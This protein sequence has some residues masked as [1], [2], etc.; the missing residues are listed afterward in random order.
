MKKMLYIMGVEWNW[1]FQRPQILAIKLQKYYDVTVVCPRQITNLKKPKVNS[2]EIRELFQLPFQ[3]KNEIIGK[4]ANLVHEMKFEDISRFDIVWIGYPIYYRY[5]PKSYKGIIIFDCMDNYAALYPDQSK[6]AISYV[7]QMQKKLLCDSDIVFSSSIRLRDS[8]SDEVQNK[9]K[10]SLIRNGYTNNGN[11]IPSIGHSKS[12]YTLGYIGTIS[13]WF[14]SELVMQSLVS[15]LNIK[16]ELIGPISR[17]DRICNSRV[18]Y[19]GTME[20]DRLGDIVKNID[21][22]IMPFVV[23]E[24]IEYVDPVK[25]YEYISWGKCIISSYYP[26]IERFTDYV[27]FYRNKEEYN[28]L[29]SKLSKEGFPAKFNKEKQEAF[30]SI[31]TWDCRVAEIMNTIT[32]YEKTNNLIGL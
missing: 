7:T 2:L 11:A 16:Y 22:L 14:D 31:N 27:Y 18:E 6:R 5:I 13:E 32:D 29:I 19:A 3:E 9:K 1:I 17:H 10:I 24:I 12:E 23:N 15:L 21:C 25:L 4:F 8:L 20:H 28:E 30:L 26:E